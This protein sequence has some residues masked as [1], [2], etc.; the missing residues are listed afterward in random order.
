MLCK[1]NYTPAQTVVIDDICTNPFPVEIANAQDLEQLRAHVEA[2]GVVL[3]STFC[4]EQNKDTTYFWEPFSRYFYDLE[5]G[6]TQFTVPT[7]TLDL[8]AVVK[9][10]NVFQNGIALPE[11]SGNAI[12]INAYTSVVSGT[13]L[14]VE[15]DNGVGHENAPEWVRIDGFV[16][17]TLAQVSGC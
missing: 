16:R 4:T 11:L 3:C 14:E 5:D 12:S 9:S 15:L 8:T 1:C 10:V 17:K 6:E 13:N 7:G 2:Q